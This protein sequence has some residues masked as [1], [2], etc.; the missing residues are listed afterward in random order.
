MLRW[1]LAAGALA[2]IAFAGCGGGGHDSGSKNPPAQPYS[3]RSTVPGVVRRV[4]PADYQAPIADYRR[5]VRRRLGTL[6]GQ[7][8][9][10]R[11]AIARG[12]LGAARSAWTRADATY[13]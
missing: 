3:T 4:T 13:E 5:Y 1:L 9:A 8:A 2:A 6:G 10:L 7:I 11:A 12:D